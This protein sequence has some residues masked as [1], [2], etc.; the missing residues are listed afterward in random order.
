M[1]LHRYGGIYADLDSEALR[2][3]D[4]LFRN[5]K[6]VLGRMGENLNFAHSIPNAF[7]ASAADQH[8]W[9]FFLNQIRRVRLSLASTDYIDMTTGEV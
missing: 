4:E 9:V 1:I 2:P 6:V 7:M 8:F 3:M 5:K